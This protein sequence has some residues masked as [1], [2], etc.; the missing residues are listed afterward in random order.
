MSLFSGPEDESMGLAWMRNKLLDKRRSL[1]NSSSQQRE[2]ITDLVTEIKQRENQLA[3]DEGAPQDEWHETLWERFIFCLTN[4]S[5]SDASETWSAPYTEGEWTFTNSD[6]IEVGYS[7]KIKYTYIPRGGGSAKHYYNGIPPKIDWELIPMM[8][9]NKT[10]FIGKARVSEIDAVCSVPQL[11]AEMDAAETAKRVLDKNRGSDEWQRRVDSKRVLSIKKFIGGENNIIANSAILYAPNHECL[12]I[13]EN[14]GRVIVDFSK[15]LDYNG[16]D[17]CDFK[18]R[19]DLR[20]IWLIDGQHRTRGLAQ[21]EIGSDVEIPIIFFPPSFDLNQS[22]KIFSEINTLQKKLSALHTLYMQHR[23]SIPSP[24]GKR[25]FSKPFK[26]P[27]GNI[28]N[29]NSRSN[30]LAYECAAYLTANKSGPLYNSIKILDQNSSNGTIITA[31]SWVDYS[32][33][34]FA[35]GAIYGPRCAENQKTINEEVENYFSAFID[36]CN[37]SGWSDGKKRWIGSGR[38]KSLLERHSPSM[39]LLRI[40]PTVFRLAKNKYPSSSPITKSEFKNILKPLTWV[41]W[42]DQKLIQYYNRSG[43]RPRTALKIWMEEAIKKGVSYPLEEVMSEEIKSKPGKGILSP[44][45]K[46]IVSLVSQNG[47]PTRHKPVEIIAKQ[48]TNSLPTAQFQILDSENVNRTA[49]NSNMIARNG[50]VTLKISYEPW[51]D[52]V[53]SLKIR[54]DWF[55]LFNPPGHGQI[56]LRRS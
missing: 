8:Q 39:T 56:T 50:S 48:P 24:L 34:W 15:F 20:P 19:N 11:P 10:F 22:A 33:F 45:G 47:W 16:Q 32:R 1:P 17:Y 6:K 31:S 29:V 7:D 36:T 30:H 5:M 46:S 23:F 55:N 40:Y 25:D 49:D 52:N 14:S 28:S 12:T 9:K 38:S 35:E 21:S 4:V 53:T 37:H 27:S 54:V 51:M 43:E 41:D 3:V 18:G 13:D 42:I 44:P 26:T 2:S